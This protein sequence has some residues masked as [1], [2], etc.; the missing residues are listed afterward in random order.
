MDKVVRPNEASR[1]FGPIFRPACSKHSSVAR[2][3]ILCP[4][5]GCPD[6][7]ELG[8]EELILQEI[9]L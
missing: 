9:F 7:P 3:S 6:K 2:T 5:F 1:F 4:I 8:T